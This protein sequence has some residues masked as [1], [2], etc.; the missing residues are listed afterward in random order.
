MGNNGP[1]ITVIICV[2]VVEAMGGRTM[3]LVWDDADLTHA[4]VGE[5]ASPGGGF[6]GREGDCAY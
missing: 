3:A 6:G 5:V 1:I 2:C 4:R